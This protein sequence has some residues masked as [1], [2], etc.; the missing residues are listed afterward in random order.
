MGPVWHPE[1]TMIETPKRN[2]DV[3]DKALGLKV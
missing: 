3:E 1:F 2:P